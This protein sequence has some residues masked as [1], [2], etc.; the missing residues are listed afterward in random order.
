M[1]AILGF[2]HLTLRTELTAKQRDYLLTDLFGEQQSPQF[3][4]RHSRF[5][6][7]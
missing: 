6:E 4:Q 1:N 2:S 3:D 7:D 5:L